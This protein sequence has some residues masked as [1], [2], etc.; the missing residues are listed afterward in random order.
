MLDWDGD[1]GGPRDSA[2]FRGFYWN[3]AGMETDIEGLPRCLKE[4]CRFPMRMYK[5]CGNADAFNYSAAIAVSRVAK[6]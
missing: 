6:K 1:D 2:R 5:K 3:T 4:C